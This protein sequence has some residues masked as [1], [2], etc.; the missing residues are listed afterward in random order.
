MSPQ[1]SA[2]P[3]VQQFTGPQAFYLAESSPPQIEDPS[4]WDPQFPPFLEFDP[5]L[6]VDFEPLEEN[7]N[8]LL[9]NY[10]P[11]PLR[12]P[13]TWTCPAG[14]FAGTDTVNDCVYTRPRRKTSRVHRRPSRDLYVDPSVLN[15]QIKPTIPGWRPIGEQEAIRQRALEAHFRQRDSSISRLPD[16]VDNPPASKQSNQTAKTCPD[17]DTPPSP[18][19]A[20]STWSWKPL[21]SQCYRGWICCIL[22]RLLSHSLLCK[23]IQWWARLVFCRKRSMGPI[24]VSTLLPATAFERC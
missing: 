16:R 13:I 2:P 11:P 4:F 21:C 9:G 24:Y 7:S 23:I 18:K 14:G 10:P 15:G 1:Q 5:W 3:L 22:F 20:I 17:C 12:L 6:P 19:T 8:A